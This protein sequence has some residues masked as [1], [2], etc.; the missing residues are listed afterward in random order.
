M[1]TKKNK[2]VSCISTSSKGISL[3]KEKTKKISKK[4]A[5]V[6]GDMTIGEVMKRKPEAAMKLLNMGLGCGGCHFAM[7][8][9]LEQGC[10]M[11]GLDVKK[12]LAEINK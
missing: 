4:V 6:T 12:V 7:I 11:H 5:I 1:A 3:R 10:C 9:T 8:E 2:P